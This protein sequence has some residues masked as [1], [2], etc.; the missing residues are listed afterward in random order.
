MGPNHLY[1]K[2][3]RLGW[4]K[5]FSAGL[6]VAATVLV[7]ALSARAETLTVGIYPY[8]PNFDQF[9]SVLKTQ[10]ATVEPNVQLNILSQDEWD[11]GY[12]MNPPDNLDVFVF[13]AM[14]FEYFKAQGFLSELQ[15]SEID[16]LTDFVDYAING[17]K[18]G[19]NYYAIPLLGCANIMFYQKSN[20]ALAQATKLSEVK[21]AL[22]QCTYTSKIPPDRRGLMLDLAGGT[23]NATFY[24]DA[25]HS[26]NGT[27]PLPL[28]QNQSQINQQAMSNVQSLLSMSSFY[29]ATVGPTAD[30]GRA[31][32][33]SEGYG[34]AMVGFTESM[35]QMTPEELDKVGFKVMP[36]SDNTQNPALFYADVIGINSKSKNRDMA[37]KLANVMAASDTVTQTFKTGGKYGNP[38]YLM[39]ARP[40]VFNALA[41]EFPIYKDMYNLIATNNPVMFA[42]DSSARDWLIPIPIKFDSLRAF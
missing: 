39:A 32:W 4:V 1:S 37:I 40:S 6:M 8:V 16:H 19:D 18:S 34:K 36:L 22:G 12:E 27:Y 38:Q 10:W 24:L 11:G 23:T 29:N 28:P 31:I 21:S 30:Y 3:N 26:I 42:L 25:A 9:V 14:L 20:Q 35:S 13:D 17:V 15:A 7:S 2:N 33:M 41:D 5:R